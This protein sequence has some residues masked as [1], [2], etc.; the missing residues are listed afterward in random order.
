MG[1]VE[2]PWHYRSLSTLR[3]CIHG[4]ADL[5]SGMHDKVLFFVLSGCGIIFLV[6]PVEHFEVGLS[7]VDHFDPFL[8]LFRLPM[9]I[10]CDLDTNLGAL[11]RVRIAY[12]LERYS[13]NQTVI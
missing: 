4:G 3:Q 8:V 6:S 10:L 5:V 12:Q 2:S 9:Y 13:L 1:A 11:V 7:L